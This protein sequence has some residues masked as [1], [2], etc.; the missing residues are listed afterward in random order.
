MQVN[1]TYGCDGIPNYCIVDEN[2]N[3]DCYWESAYCKF[4]KT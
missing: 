1:I 2:K 3:P 4:G